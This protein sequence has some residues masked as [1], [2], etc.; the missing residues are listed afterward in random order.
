MKKWFPILFG[1]V[2]LMA[3]NNAQEKLNY[4]N[5]Q[6]DWKND[7]LIGEVKTLVQYKANVI[8]SKN[9]ITEKSRI[10]FKKEYTKFG[11]ISFQEYYDNFKELKQDT[12]NEYNNK[13]LR[14]KSITNFYTMHSKMVQTNQYDTDGRLISLSIINDDSLALNARLEYNSHGDL[15]KETGIQNGDS[16]K[17][18]FEYK[19]NNN[20]KIVLKKQIQN[21]RSEKN[22]QVFIYKYNKSGNVVE[23]TNKSNIFGE[24]KLTYEYNSKNK[25]KKSS[26][27]QNGQIQK[28][29]YFDSK[30]N[31]TLIKYYENKILNR[32]M[33]FEYK[34]D[35]TGNWIVRKAFLKENFA[36]DE[37]FKPV[38]VETRKIEY[39]E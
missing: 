14:V 26:E 16:N 34:F 37:K 13:G 18:I 12:K 35:D 33:K 9:R 1:F 15:I 36:K 22:E 38:Y 2:F 20:G 6:N 27:Y 4:N 23:E 7:K 31:Q 19:Y 29:T 5:N 3:C 10:E 39:Y 21:E 8:N 30:H 32:E 11:M 25:L 28:E 17:V 24:I